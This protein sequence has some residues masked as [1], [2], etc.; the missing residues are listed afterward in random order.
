MIK[1]TKGRI[2]IEGTNDELTVEIAVLISALTM[3]LEEDEELAE[4]VITSNTECLLDFVQTIN[5][6]AKEIL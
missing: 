2:H 3:V 4:C 1:I 6:K 5:K